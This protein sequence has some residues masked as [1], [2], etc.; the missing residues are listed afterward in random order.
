MQPF[1]DQTQLS[2]MNNWGI[3]GLRVVKALL[4]SVPAKVINSSN[5]KF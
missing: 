5:L 3:L 4:G 2:F 1:H